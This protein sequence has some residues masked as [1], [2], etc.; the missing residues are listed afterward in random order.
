MAAFAVSSSKP[1]DG[2][3]LAR[4]AFFNFL[5]FLASNL[6]GIFTFLVARLLGSA[7]LGGFGLAW[8]TTDLVSKLGTLGLDTAA[9]GFVSRAEAAGDR[10]ASRRIMRSSLLLA[11][12]ART[13]L[14]ALGFWAAWTIAPRLG[15]RPELARATA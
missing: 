10:P 6:R 8:A 13:A 2:A 1:R 15:W 12:G 4:G 9:I 3:V 7:A 5:A 14:A 11:L